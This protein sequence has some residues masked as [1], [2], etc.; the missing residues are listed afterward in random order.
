MFSVKGGIILSSH[1]GLKTT[2][3]KKI[4]RKKHITSIS[5]TKPGSTKKWKDYICNKEKF[6]TL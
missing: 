3:V 1:Q 6:K 5:H 2:L 4:S